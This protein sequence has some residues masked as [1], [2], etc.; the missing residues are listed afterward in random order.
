MVMPGCPRTSDRACAARVPLP[1][2][3]PARGCFV[4]GAAVAALVALP[5]GRPTFLGLPTFL[6]RPAFLGRPG[7]RPGFLAGA[8]AA[9]AAAGA[10]PPTLA[11]AGA[12]RKSKR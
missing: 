1:L 10:D 9:A 6:G 12:D 7:G 3:R 8:A 4:V 2:G 5:A 11:S